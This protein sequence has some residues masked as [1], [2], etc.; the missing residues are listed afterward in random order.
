MYIRVFEV[1]ACLHVEVCMDYD[2]CLPYINKRNWLLL[3]CY[4][5]FLLIDDDSKS[6]TYKNIIIFKGSCR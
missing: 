5:Q 6:D 1:V 3:V 4:R 2:A